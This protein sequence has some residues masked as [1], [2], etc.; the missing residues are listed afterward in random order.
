MRAIRLQLNSED[1]IVFTRN[2]D[3]RGAPTDFD[4]INFVYV[5]DDKAAELAYE[6]GE[7]DIT[8]ITPATAVRYK[9]SP[10]ANSKVHIAGYPKYM[11]LGMNTQY[12]KLTDIRVRQ[13]I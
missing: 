5:E 12:A 3:W 6:A 8:Q 11:W 1:T 7:L 4:Q 2:P 9:S 13:A 10:P